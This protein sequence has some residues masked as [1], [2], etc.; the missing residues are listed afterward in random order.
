VTDQELQAV[1]RGLQSSIGNFDNSLSAINRRMIDMANGVRDEEEEM[2]KNLAKMGKWN[3]ETDD[4][5]KQ[6]LEQQRRDYM[7]AKEVEKDL[8]T[9][10]TGLINS[11]AKTESEIQKHAAALHKAVADEKAGIAGAAQAR[12]AAQAALKQER[13]NKRDHL[14]QLNSVTTELVNATNTQHNIVRLMRKTEK[15]LNEFSWKDASKKVGTKLADTLGQGVK[16]IFSGLTVGNAVNTWYKGLGEVMATGGD[17]MFASLDRQMDAVQLGLTPEEYIKMNAASRQTILATGGVGKQLDILKKQS[18]DLGGSF[19]TAGDATRYAQGQMDALAKGGIRPSM[20]TAGLLNDQFLRLNKITGMTGEQFNQLTNELIT[21]SDIQLQLR[22][23]NAD[24]RQQIIKSN[25]ARVAEYVAM[26]MTTEQAKS[27]TKA[28]AAI[29]GQKPIDRI[30][31]AAKLR[32][33]GGAMGIEGANEAADIMIKGQRASPEEMKRLA[34]FNSKMSNKMSESAKG[35]IGGEIF[36]SKI[37]EKLGTKDTDANSVFN[38]RLTEGNKI[39]EESLKTLQEVPKKL[40]ELIRL[41]SQGG[42]LK[43]NPLAQTAG[44]A[45]VSL[46]DTFGPGAMGAAG[47]WAGAKFLGKAAPTVVPDVNLPGDGPKPPPGA[48]GGLKSAGKTAGKF[49][50][51]KLPVVGALAGL[52][53]AASRAMDGDWTGAGMEAASGVAS[54]AP[55]VGTAASVG[56]DAALMARDADREAKELAKQRARDAAGMA[57]ITN[58]DAASIMAKG[59]RA[60]HEERLALADFNQKMS[61]RMLETP[62]GSIGSEIFSSKLQDKL[63]AGEQPTANTPPLTSA[64]ARADAASPIGLQLS[65]MEQSANHLK[66]ITDLATKQVDLAEKQLAAT[67]VSG[68]D[69]SKL[70]K[71]LSTGNRFMTT[72]NTLQ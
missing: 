24:E 36:A 17:N 38:T 40:Q 66:N 22:A 13:K 53:Y 2:R 34:D 43:A 28:L 19:A 15:E 23:A 3:K 21:D 60:S 65:L 42:A 37:Q 54:L 45:G 47:G 62:T 61:N 39:Q 49:M 33:M 41:V 31:Q 58:D 25:A 8:N 64:E 70:F 4:L 7:A 26:G 51:K 72:Y 56:I 10:K 57:G 12:A 9:A 67:L 46:W 69:R 35:S 18:S 44:A 1:I 11:I 30:K 27:A 71:E 14:N 6:Q 63:G 50:L 20:E 29:A 32:A 16:N 68:E 52:G 5:R 55:G 48:K 59:P